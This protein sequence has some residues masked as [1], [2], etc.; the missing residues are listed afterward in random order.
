MARPNGTTF[1]PG[2]VQYVANGMRG[3]RAAGMPG[4]I[5]G[6][7][8]QEWFGP[9]QPTAPVTPPG[10]DPRLID[11]PF[12]VNLQYQ[13]RALENGVSYAQLEMLADGYD[14]L[15]L[16]IETRK[17]Q[18]CKMS[19][20]LRV[21]PGPGE[22]KAD[23]KKK[24]E[25]DPRITVLKEFF[26]SPD[27]VHDWQTWLRLLLEDLFVIDAPAVLVRRQEDNT[28]W[29]FEPIHGAT[30]TRLIDEQGRTP[31][32]PSPGYRQILKGVPGPFLYSGF[33]GDKD[34]PELVYRPRNRRPRKMYGYSPVEQ[35]LVTVN[36]A[37]RRQLSQL[38]Y[39]TEGNIPEALVSLPATWTADQIK[40]WQDQ[41]DVYAGDVAQKRR[42]RWV[43]EIKA[44]YGTK[45]AMLKDE[46]D[47]WLAR[48][49]C[50]NFSISPQPFVK[51]MNKATAATAQQTAL[52]E[53]LIPLLE[54]IT[55]FVNYLLHTYIENTEDIEW[56]FD[57]AEE[58]DKLKQAQIDTARV[59][60]GIESVDEIRERDGLDPIGCHN[61]VMTASG[62]VFL[63]DIIAASAAGLGAGSPGAI[64]AK[65]MAMASA[66]LNGTGGGA[67]S[68]AST[69]DTTLKLL[70]AGK[71]KR[72]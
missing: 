49:I 70:K 48:I 18:V 12:G 51:M 37:L 29:G 4:F 32:P 10:T 58:S 65:N 31:L 23:A 36:M 14:L 16:V 13:P 1:D 5:L 7:T 57:D 30:I 19:W 11:Y 72:Y 39:Y 9:L 24:T 22:K 40:K 15:R 38:S 27:R 54:W 67:G 41:F 59:S 21:T 53:G 26:K 2:I 8:G 28:L 3:A 62:P 44:F 63:S 64:E 55:A 52:S 43:P 6:L 56:A 17:D 71:K 33:T 42:I 69:D 46:F 66:S 34:K 68:K 47:E 50:F 25:L 35:I 60:I 45:D 61:F 20:G